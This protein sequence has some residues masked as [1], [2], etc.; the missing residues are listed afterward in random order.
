MRIQPIQQHSTLLLAGIVAILIVIGI[1]LKAMHNMA[2]YME[3]MTGHV[4]DMANDIDKMRGSFTILTSEISKFDDVIVHMDENIN[5]MNVDINI[6][7]RSMSNDMT[8]IS[9]NLELTAS[10]M[11]NVDYSMTILTKE[12]NQISN[13][14]RPMAV[15]IHRGTSSFTSPMNYMWNMMQ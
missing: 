6:I 14:M 8:S 5:A 11:G 7:Q 3:A 2:S 1:A 12:V 4:A 9:K 10:Y 13:L 15:D